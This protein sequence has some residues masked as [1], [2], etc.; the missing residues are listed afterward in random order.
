M[1]KIIALLITFIFACSAFAADI[2][3]GEDCHVPDGFSSV[4]ITSSDGTAIQNAV[5]HIQDGGTIELSGNFYLKKTINIKKNLT[6]KGTDN[7]VLDRSQATDKNR[8]IRCEG[9]ITLENLTITGGYSFNG[10]GVKLDGGTVKI[11]NCNIH[12]NTGVFGGGGIN[13]QAENFTLTNSTISNNI[14]AFA[15]GGISTVDGTIT[16]TDC[17]I[18]DNKA[19]LYGGGVGALGSTITMTN[20]KITGNSALKNGGTDQGKGG[21]VALIKAN[22]TTQNCEISGNTASLSPD[23]YYDENS[24]YNK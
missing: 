14:S 9:N 16:I 18:T 8:V 12:G 4:L 11:I 19:Q 2:D 7:A 5:E 24:T 15:G 1:K 3:L 10:G 13:S 23:I 20:C 17:N 6:I 22:L 21:G